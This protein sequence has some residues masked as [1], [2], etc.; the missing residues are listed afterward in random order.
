[1]ASC[2]I[3]EVLTRALPHTDSQ[4]IPHPFLWQEASPTLNSALTFPCTAGGGATFQIKGI[5]NYWTNISKGTTRVV[6][7]WFLLETYTKISFLCTHFKLLQPEGMWK[8]VMTTLCHLL[9]QHPLLQG[10]TTVWSFWIQ[11]YW[12]QESSKTTLQKNL[13]NF[14]EDLNETFLLEN[15]CIWFISSSITIYCFYQVIFASQ[16]LAPALA[17]TGTSISIRVF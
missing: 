10:S 14:A 9:D 12:L 7:A 2:M 1:M 5:E 16:E 3:H 17:S 8:R 11:E 15:I 6:S 4:V 13:A